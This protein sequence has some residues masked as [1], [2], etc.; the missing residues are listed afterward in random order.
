[1][2]A[3]FGDSQRVLHDKDGFTPAVNRDVEV[4]SDTE[5]ETEETTECDDSITELVN[6]V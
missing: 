2:P 3:T 5:S 6:R 4:P 1:M